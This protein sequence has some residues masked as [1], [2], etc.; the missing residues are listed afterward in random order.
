VRA[1]SQYIKSIQSG[2]GT[3]DNRAGKS[4]FPIGIQFPELEGEKTE[5]A[6][7][8]A[9]QPM[10]EADATDPQTLE[11]AMR[12]S[13]WT[14]WES[15]I[16]IELDALKRAGTWGLVERPKGRNI[17]K[18][19]WVFRVKKNAEGRIEKYKARLVAKGFTQ[20]YGVDYYDTWAPV[21]K[22]A[23]IRLILDIAAQN[24]WPIE[25][26]D[27]HS[28]FLN[29]ELDCDEEI[30]MEQPHGYEEF[31]KKGYVCKLFKSLYGLKQAGRKW[32]EV[33]CRTLGDLGFNRSETDPAVFY[34]HK[35]KDI[36][37]LAC[38][39]DDC[40]ITGN[41]QHLLQS[42]RD[43]IKQKYSLTDLGAINWL[44]GIKI[45]R[46][47]DNQTISLSQSSYIDS[48]LTRFNFVDLKPSAIPMDPSIRFSKDQCP[49]TAEEV[50]DMSKVPY[51]EAIGSLNHCA[52]AT[53]PDI[54]FSVSLLAQF[55]DN[56]GRVH[57][58]A[59]KRVFRYLLGTRNWKL[60]Y[61]MT[62]RGL[63][64]YTDADG[65]SQEHRRAISGY[66]FLVNGGAISWS[67]KKQELVTLSTAESEYVAA[68]HAAKEA[69]W[70]RQIVNEVFEPINKPTILHSDS[71]LA[72]AFT[73][74][75]S[76]HART[77]HIDIRYHFIR[78]VVQNGS[79]NPI[80]CPTNSD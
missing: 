9:M 74:D 58:E 30:F 22:L 53:R 77:K 54:S 65:S 66:V 33:L 57:W 17:V 44:L 3:A 8:A 76:Y 69:L 73:K 12:Q 39:V 36:V 2:T 1:P 72:I 28:A 16:R 20:V 34:V 63:E 24:S 40:T 61:G 37:V 29:G 31:D 62:E 43:K 70:L 6:M 55:M 68:T 52:V 67:S 46:D 15:A 71:Q 7:A 18:C 21:A 50:E 26:F 60:V 41:S 11:E 42:Y 23:S 32:Y 64:G 45:T 10:P 59:I 14:Q 80:Y 25:M 56:P 13:D 5:R 47:L 4:K 78:S 19:K 48:I 79:I 75:G 49:K 35:G 51:R 27:F 38:H